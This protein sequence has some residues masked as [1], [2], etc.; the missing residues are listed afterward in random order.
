ME[1]M[2]IMKT[3]K[4][5]RLISVSLLTMSVML[6]VLAC[7]GDSDDDSNG[8]T[9]GG[10]SGTG[11]SAGDG[12]GGTAGGGGGSG[13]S[14]DAGQADGAAAL[15]QDVAEGGVCT[16]ITAFFSSTGTCKSSSDCPGGLPTQ[17]DL[18][19][20]NDLDPIVTTFATTPTSDQANCATGLTC[21]VDTDQCPSAGEQIN[22][23]EM[24]S[25]VL[26]GDVT[27]VC[28]SPGGCTAT[29]DG[30]AYGEITVGCPSGQT[31][32]VNI[33]P[34]TLPEGGVL[35]TTDAGEQTTDS[36]SQQ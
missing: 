6:I 28:G 17:F 26:G 31:C 22:G 24:I 14:M 33:P 1:A 36:G 20:L 25:T 15:P 8:G 34:I 11:G 29:G 5:F 21:C 7:G 12:T 2:V 9:G 23:N 16:M 4:S 3:I 13:G 27:T 10:A 35:P 18:S 32:C 19:T 30:Y